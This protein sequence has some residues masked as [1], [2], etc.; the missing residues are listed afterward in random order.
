[1]NRR[2]FFASLF[3]FFGAAATPVLVKIA[4]IKTGW[5]SM[6]SMPMQSMVDPIKGAKIRTRDEMRALRRLPPLEES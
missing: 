2:G 6:Q 1:M 5:D 4:P 3:G